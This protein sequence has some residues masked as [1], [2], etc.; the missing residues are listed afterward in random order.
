MIL[1]LSLLVIRPGKGENV[2]THLGTTP[3]I[4]VLSSR[5]TSHEIQ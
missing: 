4:F 2:I 5:V 1:T 3:A